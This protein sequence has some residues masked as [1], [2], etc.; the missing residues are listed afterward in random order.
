MRFILVRHGETQ[1]NTSGRFGGYTDV[2]LNEKGKLQADNAGRKLM[3]E[4]INKVYC[5]D[6][7]RA[8]DTAKAIMKHHN[9]PIHYSQDIREMNFGKWEGL[10]YKQILEDYPDLSKKWVEDYTNVACLEGESLKMFYDR[11]ADAFKNIREQ[12][13]EDET[14]LIVA[15]SGVIKGILC[16]EIIGSV[17]GFWKF[18]VEN[19]GIVLL[20]YDGDFPILSALNM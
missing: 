14:V 4:S 17:D 20:E 7:S 6:L 13:L 12:T 5:S 1:W 18:K 19:G 2:P 10:T 15:H 9:L 11:I 8:R 16:K 3:N